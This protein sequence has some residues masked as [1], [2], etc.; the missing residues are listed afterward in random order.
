MEGISHPLP[1]LKLNTMENQKAEA[2]LREATLLLKQWYR[3]DPNDVDLDI[4]V[5]EESSSIGET[6]K[7]WLRHIG[8]KYDLI[9]MD[10]ILN[11]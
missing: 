7:Q 1:R 11:L 4:T 5:A 6:P 8:K 9:R 3:L 10:K 2:W